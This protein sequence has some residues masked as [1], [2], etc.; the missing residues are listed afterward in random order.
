MR[1][2]EINGLLNKNTSNSRQPEENQRATVARRKIARQIRAGG[3]CS[4]RWIDRYAHQRRT[5]EREIYRSVQRQAVILI[6]LS[7]PSQ[8]TDTCGRERQRKR[9]GYR[10]EGEISTQRYRR[11][12]LREARCR[13]RNGNRYGAGRKAQ[14]LD[15]LL[16]DGGGGA[17]GRRRTRRSSGRASEHGEA[18][19]QEPKCVAAKEERRW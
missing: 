2:R 7:Q 3:I 4:A 16:L 15:L 14:A 13:T 12:H 18:E 9:G 11:N 17:R 1:Y 8:T 5:R 6:V 19:T 10:A